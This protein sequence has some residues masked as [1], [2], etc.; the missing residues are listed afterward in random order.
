MIKRNNGNKIFMTLRANTKYQSFL[1]IKKL[2][3][4]HQE[5]CKLSITINMATRYQ[6]NLDPNKAY[7]QDN[8]VFINQ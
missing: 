6:R 8:G 4:L 7:Q 1:F 5:I 3:F 2:T